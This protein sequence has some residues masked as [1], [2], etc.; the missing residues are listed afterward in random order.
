LGVASRCGHGLRATLK[1]YNMNSLVARI[2]GFH[3]MDEKGNLKGAHN[4]TGWLS[5]S[6]ARAF[7]RAWSRRHN[8]PTR[9]FYRAA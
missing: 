7:A 6:E 2:E 8:L 3:S 5:V 4:L 9:I 1:E